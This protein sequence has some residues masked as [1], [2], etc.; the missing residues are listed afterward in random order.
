MLDHRE[1]NELG[2]RFRQVPRCGLDQA[3]TRHP[4]VRESIKPRDERDEIASQLVAH[5]RDADR[6]GSIGF[7][8]LAVRL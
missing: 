8:L 7:S 5:C 2:G 6:A 1:S 4:Y 3:V